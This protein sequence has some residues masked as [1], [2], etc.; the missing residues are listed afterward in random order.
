MCS[1]AE[2][3]WGFRWGKINLNFSRVS[4]CIFLFE[5]YDRSLCTRVEASSLDFLLASTPPISSSLE[6]DLQTFMGYDGHLFLFLFFLN[7]GARLRSV[8]IEKSCSSSFILNNSSRLASSLALAFW[9][10]ESDCS[11]VFPK[12]CGRCY[13][14]HF[15]HH[16]LPYL[17]IP[18]LICTVFISRG[19]IYGLRNKDFF[20]R[21]I[22]VSASMRTTSSF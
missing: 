12:M 13:Q 1:I 8:L 6:C 18:R 20:S 15:V 7:V 14:I 10:S 16:H 17:L 21:N 2:L 19:L 11:D 9:P 5:C 22:A 3:E 4:M